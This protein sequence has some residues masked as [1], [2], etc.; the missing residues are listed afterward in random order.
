MGD[1]YEAAFQG[2]RPSLSL[3][4]QC[5]NLNICDIRI[6][7]GLRDG[8][9]ATRSHSMQ[10]KELALFDRLNTVLEQLIEWRQQILLGTL[11]A[12]RA[13]RVVCLIR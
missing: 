13:S 3:A 7:F 9:V 11:S 5:F 1:Y 4:I 10:N 2:L 12:V 8:S 6:S